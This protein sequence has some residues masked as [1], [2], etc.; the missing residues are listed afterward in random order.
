VFVTTT[1]DLICTKGTLFFSIVFP[2]P[3]PPPQGK[4][5]SLPPHE[6]CSSLNN[7]QFFF[8]NPQSVEEKKFTLPDEPP[9]F[10]LLDPA[11][12]F[13]SRAALFPPPKPN[14]NGLY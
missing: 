4:E 11:L 5:R 13:R 9:P 12:P 3:P 7:P 14:S 8:D 2:P 6:I 10:D 1:R